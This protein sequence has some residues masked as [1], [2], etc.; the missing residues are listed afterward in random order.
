LHLFGQEFVSR[1]DSRLVTAN[2][3]EKHGSFLPAVPEQP[4]REVVIEVEKADDRP[5]QII[6]RILSQSCAQDHIFHSSLALNFTV[7]DE[8]TGDNRVA[9]PKSTRGGMAGRS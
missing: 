8:V 1:G 3:Y 9:N 7:P 4:L 6:Q 2:R 5:N